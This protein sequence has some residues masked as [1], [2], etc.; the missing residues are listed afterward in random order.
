MAPDF[1]RPLRE[2]AREKGEKAVNV[3][4]REGKERSNVSPQEDPVPHGFQRTFA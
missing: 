3:W 2:G 4:N 1:V